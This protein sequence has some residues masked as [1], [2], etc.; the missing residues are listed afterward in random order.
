MSLKGKLEQ[1]VEHT[2]ENFLLTRD[3][4]DEDY[5][6]WGAREDSPHNKSKSMQ[7]GKTMNLI[8]TE[9]SSSFFM[10]LTVTRQPE[11]QINPHLCRLPRL[12]PDRYE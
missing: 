4:M 5:C 2:V 10:L 11:V 9:M 12:N 3:V 7:N 8:F 1:K 6:V